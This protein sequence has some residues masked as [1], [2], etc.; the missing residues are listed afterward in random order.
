MQ[1][2]CS[3][4]DKESDFTRYSINMLIRS[5][6]E[7]TAEGKKKLNEKMHETKNH[8]TEPKAN[9]AKKEGIKKN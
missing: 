1:D 5:S 4:L 8:C 3:Q 6:I 9:A 2:A 7:C